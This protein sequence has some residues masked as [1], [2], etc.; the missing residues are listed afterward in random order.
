MVKSYRQKIDRTAR[1]PYFC[2]MFT[3]AYRQLQPAERAYVDGYVSHAEA[4]AQRLG[5]HISLALYRPIPDD[6][7][8]ASRGL[9]DRPL[10]LA[11]IHERITEIGSD[12]ELS[13]NR[14]ARELVAIA[15]SNHQDYH[16]VDQFGCPTANMDDLPREKW[17]AIESVEIEMDPRSPNIVRKKKIKLYSKLQALDMLLKLYD[18]EQVRLREVAQLGSPAKRAALPATVTV[19]S[20]AEAYGALI[21]G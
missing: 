20:A 21:N 18:P 1:H 17:A 19:E 5:E 9:L 8:E 16:M 2:A 11:A 7:K 14:V 3:S 15:F 13:I 6:V 4:L 10:V 12:T